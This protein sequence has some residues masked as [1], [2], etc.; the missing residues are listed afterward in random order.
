MAGREG[1][2]LRE[3][4]LHRAERTHRLFRCGGTG[5]NRQR[6]QYDGDDDRS[7]HVVNSHGSSS[8]QLFPLGHG[9]SLF[10]RTETFPRS[11]I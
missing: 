3:D 11:K 4:L 5:A 10:D 6:L 8:L 2:A 7:D 9:A 1:A